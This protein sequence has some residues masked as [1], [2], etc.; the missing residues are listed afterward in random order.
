MDLN[1]SALVAIPSFITPA[2]IGLFLYR[3]FIPTGYSLKR[4]DFTVLM[5]VGVFTAYL[6]LDLFELVIQKAYSSF[7]L[8]SQNNPE[9][10]IWY[11]FFQNS[12]M[13]SDFP[14]IIF[15][16]IPFMRQKEAYSIWDVFVLLHHRAFLFWALVWGLIRVLESRLD[17]ILAKNDGDKT[18]R[19]SKKKAENSLCLNFFVFIITSLRKRL[20]S[21]WSILFRH[22]CR[23][24]SKVYQSISFIVYHLISSNVY[25]SISFKVYHPIS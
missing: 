21:S 7:Y 5:I 17:V 3:F 16:K 14:W 4:S 12:N 6:N 18:S 11:S 2:L 25:Q 8:G 13:K 19:R 23:I 15:N 1:L 24:S 10:R 22:N 9:S 20:Y